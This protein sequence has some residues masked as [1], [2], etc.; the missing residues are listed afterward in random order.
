M[1]VVVLPDTLV[2]ESFTR[3]ITRQSVDIPTSGAYDM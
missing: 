3:T 1:V 2:C